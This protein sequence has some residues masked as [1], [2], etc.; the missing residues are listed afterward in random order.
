MSKDERN[1]EFVLGELSES[2][3]RQHERLLAQDPM[4]AQEASEIRA[5]LQDFRDLSVTPTQ[6]VPLRI[7]YAIAQRLRLR[8]HHGDRMP[9][10]WRHLLS[11]P[12]P[13][14][15]RRASGGS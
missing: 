4:L 15:C 12:H 1:T 9:T 10:S 7:R 6:N 8:Q 11:H 13:G 3:A 5:M 14:T 2:D